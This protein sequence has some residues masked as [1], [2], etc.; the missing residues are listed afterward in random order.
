MVHDAVDDLL[1]RGQAQRGQVSGAGRAGEDQRGVPGVI[2]NSWKP[3]AYPFAGVL[4]GSRRKG[5]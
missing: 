2:T 4:A 1:V 3:G 5:S